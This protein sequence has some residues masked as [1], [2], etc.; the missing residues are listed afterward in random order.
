[1]SE[2]MS[3]NMTSGCFGKVDIHRVVGEKVRCRG[4][5]SQKKVRKWKVN[6][7]FIFKTVHSKEIIEI[8]VKTKFI[9]KRLSSEF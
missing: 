4:R 9:L 7:W 2:E 6:A 8:E 3:W 1:M 5:R